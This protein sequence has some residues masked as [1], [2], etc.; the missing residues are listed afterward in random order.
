MFR[1]VI[2]FV[3]A[4]KDILLVDLDKLTLPEKWNPCTVKGLISI[5][6]VFGLADRFYPQP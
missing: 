4:E 2:E 1:R 3:L 5:Q 6:L